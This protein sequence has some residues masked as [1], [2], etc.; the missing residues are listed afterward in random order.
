MKKILLLFVMLLALTINV[1]AGTCDKA[2]LSR[3]KQLAQK[4]EFDYDYK[5]VDGEAK[6]SIEV[7]NLN[8]DLKVL[9]I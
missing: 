2:E 3:L 6:F 4:L 5:V 8:I 9:I 7:A 1:H